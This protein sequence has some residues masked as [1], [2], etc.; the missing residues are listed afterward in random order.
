MNLNFEKPNSWNENDIM[1]FAKMLRKVSKP[2]IIAA[3]KIDRPYGKENLERIKGEFDYLIIPCFAEGELALREADKHGLIDYIPGESSF[4]IKQIPGDKQKKALDAIDAIL[5]EFGS[6]GIQNV[7]NYIIFD[8]LKYVA[9]YPA[10]VKL[11]DNQGRVLPDCF[12]MPPKTTALD[13]AFRLHS[14][15]GNSFVK[16]I[17]LKTKRAVGKDYVLKNRDALEI[18][19]R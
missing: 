6:T 4:E 12:L 5:K 7:L 15:I 9:I 17:D 13:F 8:I 2:M 16:A 11:T 10:S 14:D 1:L 18:V 3:N 19:C